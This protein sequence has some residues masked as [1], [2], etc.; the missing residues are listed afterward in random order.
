MTTAQ[1]DEPL[2][3]PTC[4]FNKWEIW[5]EQ[6]ESRGNLVIVTAICCT[7][8]GGMGCQTKMRIGIVPN[9]EIIAV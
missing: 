1:G 8:S 3:C 5:G 6:F 2:V 9:D 7:D 4:G